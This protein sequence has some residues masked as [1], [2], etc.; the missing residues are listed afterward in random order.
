MGTRSA[1]KE[2]NGTLYGED[3]LNTVEG[4]YSN[5]SETISDGGIFGE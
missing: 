5:L 4:R 2:E 3:L 1:L